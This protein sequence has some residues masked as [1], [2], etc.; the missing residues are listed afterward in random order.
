[1]YISEKWRGSTLG[2]IV[3]SV[4]LTGP[5]KLDIQIHINP[6]IVALISFKKFIKVYE[7]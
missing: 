4:N 6:E 3:L 5:Q 1:M 2:E 7:L